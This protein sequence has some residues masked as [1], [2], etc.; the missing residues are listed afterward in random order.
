MLLDFSVLDK[1]FDHVGEE[2]IGFGFLTLGF[3]FPD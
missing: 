1:D 2:V 3:P